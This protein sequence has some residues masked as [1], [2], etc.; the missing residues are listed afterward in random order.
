MSSQKS[1]RYPKESSIFAGLFGLLLST[2]I[3]RRFFVKTVSL[4]YTCS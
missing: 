4:R 3:I 1:K 2:L